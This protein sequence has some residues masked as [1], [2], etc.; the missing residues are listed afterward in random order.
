M[1]IILPLMSEDLSNKVKKLNRLS[2][3]Y[4]F[5]IAHGKPYRV[6]RIR[7]LYQSIF[8]DLQRK[9]T[10]TILD[11]HNYQSLFGPDSKLTYL[12]EKKELA[13]KKGYYEIAAQLRDQEKIV[14]SLRLSNLGFDVNENFIIIGD[15]IYQLPK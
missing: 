7:N 9:Y 4:D 13:V 12:L 2:R 6:S 14:L 3:L 15:G 5:A 11:S 1:P 8:T 10:I